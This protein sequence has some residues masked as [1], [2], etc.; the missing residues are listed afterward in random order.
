MHVWYNIDNQASSA[1]FDAEIVDKV[2]AGGERPS[3]RA[4]LD[5]PGWDAGVGALTEAVLGRGAEGEATVRR[6]RKD[7]QTSRQRPR[8]GQSFLWKGYFGTSFER[9]CVTEEADD[10]D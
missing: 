2:K 1:L 6:T 5:L 4:P 9:D 3:A 7:S 10:I 8:V